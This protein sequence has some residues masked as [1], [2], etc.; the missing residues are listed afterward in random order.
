MV[1]AQGVEQLVQIAVHDEVELVQGQADAVVAILSANGF[2][3][4]VTRLDLAGI[5]RA[6]AA[7]RT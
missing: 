7:R 3:G 4:C 1:G 6:V 2:E 5:P